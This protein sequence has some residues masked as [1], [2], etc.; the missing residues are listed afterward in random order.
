MI[1][2]INDIA[3]K[4]PLPEPKEGDYRDKDGILH[5]GVCHKPLERILNSEVLGF[6][7]KKVTCVCDCDEKEKEEFDQRLNREQLETKVKELRRDG[8][9]KA[10]EEMTFENSDNRNS[11]EIKICK[12]FVSNWAKVY[13]ER[14]GGLLFYGDTG[15]GKSFLSCCIA[16]ALLDKGVPTLVTNL[17]KL[18]RDRN[19]KSKTPINLNNFDLLVLD[20]IG[21]E[22]AS[23]TAYN[24][25]D[26]WYQTGKPL[27]V[28]TNLTPNELKQPQTRELKR[29]YDRIIEMCPLPVLVKGEITRLDTA[30]NKRAELEKILG[31]I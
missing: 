22:N 14:K 7:N 17:S 2:L 30:R 4:N 8:I 29:I 25:I 16:N 19:D 13:K 10:Y 20:D 5:C 31:I 15:T 21:V 11:K 23:Q 6:K 26:E 18:V 24:I 9:T 28:T 1:N 27:I 12:S 3:N